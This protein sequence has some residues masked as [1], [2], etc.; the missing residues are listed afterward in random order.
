M[1][2]LSGRILNYFLILALLGVSQSE[3]STGLHTMALHHDQKVELSPADSSNSLYTNLDWSLYLDLGPVNISESYR[4]ITNL[5]VMRHFDETKGNYKVGLMPDDVMKISPEFVNT[6]YKRERD[7]EDSVIQYID[8]SNL[9]SHFI[10]AVQY[11]EITNSKML[12]Q[13]VD[14]L[15][16]SINMMD[17]EVKS[18]EELMKNDDMPIQ[19]IRLQTE[20]IETKI[21]TMEYKRR[22][23]RLKESHAEILAAQRT[24]SWQN[25]HEEYRLRYLERLQDFTDNITAIAT[26][27]SRKFIDFYEKDFLRELEYEKFIL[28][29]EFF[30]EERKLN[31]EKKVSIAT[32][33]HRISEEIRIEKSLE[34]LTA[35]LLKL[36]YFYRMKGLESASYEIV[37]LLKTM[38][39]ENILDKPQETIR[40]VVV[41]SLSLFGLVIIAQLKELWA[42]YRRNSNVLKKITLKSKLVHQCTVNASLS[43]EYDHSMVDDQHNSNQSRSDMSKNIVSQK[44]C[45]RWIQ[46]RQNSPQSS[47][48][49]YFISVNTVLQQ[50]Y[51]IIQQYEYHTAS[52]LSTPLQ[53]P[54]ILVK[55]PHG[56]GKSYFLEVLTGSLSI[57]Y[58]IINGNDLMTLEMSTAGRYLQDTIDY[59]ISRSA[60]RSPCLLIVDN[61]DS[62]ISKRKDRLS[63]SQSGYIPH[64]CLYILMNNMRSNSEKISFILT[65]SSDFTAVDEAVLDRID[66]TIDLPLP[67]LK[68]RL[69]FIIVT[70]LELFRD[71]LIEDDQKLL[72]SLH[73]EGMTSTKYL[74]IL[75]E[76]ERIVKESLTYDGYKKLVQKFVTTNKISEIEICILLTTIVTAEFTYRNVMKLLTNVRSIVLGTDRSATIQRRICIP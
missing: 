49:S 20:I 14:N 66:I 53:L 56:N 40:Y 62:I 23:I 68:Q 2:H 26:E 4:I 34:E 17:E 15:Y 51:H 5:K 16:R 60:Q 63:S 24:S 65:T 48:P 45:E 57:S 12:H 58:C 59:I 74:S 8:Y 31:M 76:A 70:S 25:L 50:T 73:Y 75:R 47:I 35:K 46:F 7:S 37:Q 41:I 55:C 44:S 64:C 1:T 54:N 32:A 21:R 33:S 27:Y 28:E 6:V 42:I 9:L 38:W 13:T 19:D 36:K 29:E 11:F 10:G 43:I 30:E 69:D 22:L 3:P 39:K 67:S 72:T 71:M 18:I 61:A 52:N